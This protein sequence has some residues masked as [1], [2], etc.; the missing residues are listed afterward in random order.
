MAF[1]F[2]DIF[3]AL[4][5]QSVAPQQTI[6]PTADLIA[7]SQG[8]ASAQ[9]P[10]LNSY[11][12]IA[13]QNLGGQQRTYLG[14][15]YGDQFNTLQD[16]TT[17]SF[18]DNLNLGTSLS[19][20]LT[21]DI[22]RKLSETGS[23]SGFGYSPAG[24]GNI[25]L[26]TGLE[27]DALGRQRRLDAANYGQGLGQSVNTFRP[28]EGF[29]LGD[30]ASN[31]QQTQAAQ[32]QVSN[33]AEQ[34]RLQNFAS[35]LNTGGRILGMAGGA[36][37]G[38]PAGASIGGSIG[39]SL[40]QGQNVTGYGQPAGPNALNQGLGALTGSMS[41]ANSPWNS[42]GFDWSSLG[43]SGG[44]SNDLDYGITGGGTRGGR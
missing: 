12:T 16:N 43:R 9:Q 28:S 11:N 10:W 38:G 33:L 15:R 35:L 40:I 39:G 30:F 29:S 44:L 14:S 7:Q 3:G 6:I 19:P 5:G 13:A 2:G 34:T 42:G 36:F 37:F 22:T 26:Q 1:E 25:A 24:I 17:K 31:I 8:Y 18:L 32:D 23:L 4:T 20:E 21:A 27:A 41:G